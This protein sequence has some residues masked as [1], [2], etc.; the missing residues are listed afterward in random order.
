MFSFLSLWYF[1]P[2][3]IFFFSF[4]GG[5]SVFPVDPSQGRPGA[6][7]VV[8]A[9]GSMPF[10]VFRSSYSLLLSVNFK[11]YC[12]FMVFDLFSVLVIKLILC[13]LT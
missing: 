6:G 11:C 13:I 12:L 5:G 1:F 2:V 3:L 8:R 9:S 7:C 4:S 10:N